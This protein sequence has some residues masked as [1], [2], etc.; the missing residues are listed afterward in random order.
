MKNL[1]DEV[2]RLTNI[3][4]LYDHEVKLIPYLPKEVARAYTTGYDVILD[5]YN[6]RSSFAADYAFI[7][8]PVERIFEL[9]GEEYN[10]I[11]AK[12]RFILVDNAAASYDDGRIDACIRTQ[13]RQTR[14]GHRPEQPAS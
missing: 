4:L 1:A 14:P 11:V 12:N 6:A 10:A 7:I 3:E 13:G 5:E 9:S 2:T 8:I